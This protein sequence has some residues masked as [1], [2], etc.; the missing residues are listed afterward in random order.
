MEHQIWLLRNVF[1]WYLLA[2]AA[3]MGAF[4]AHLTWLTWSGGWSARLLMAGIAAIIALVL[5]GVYGLN[6]N[7][8]RKELEPRRA[9]LLDLIANLSRTGEGE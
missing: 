1:W 6:Q 8:V 4:F 3:A 7:C 9:E 5:W 2:P